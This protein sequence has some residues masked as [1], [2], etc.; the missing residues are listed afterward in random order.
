MNSTKRFL[1]VNRKRILTAVLII[2]FLTTVAKADIGSGVFHKGGYNTLK[3]MLTSL[4]MPDLSVE[5][6][7]IAIKSCWQTF[8]YALISI[9]LA[10]IMAF[11]LAV[12]ASGIIFHNRFL[13]VVMRGIIGFLRAI[14][15][16]IWAWIFVAAVGLTPIG[17]IF[18]L[19]IPYAGYFGK[20]FADTLIETPKAPL[21]A[22]KLSGAGRLQIFFYGY[23]PS[24]FPNM[25]SYIIYRLECAIRSSSV[26]SFVGLGG[27]GFQIQ[28][29]L[30]DLKYNQVWT[31]MFFLIAMILIIDKW[32]YEIRRRVK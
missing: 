19:A 29:S 26:L 18:A 32:G 6:I 12:L 2:I 3:S 24:A 27:I 21:T 4:F 23:L 28:I 11:P 30:Q 15:E 13:M 14:H 31:F 17:A 20:I 5:I 1:V 25:F 7:I 22:L 9:S 16:L 10:V 8:S